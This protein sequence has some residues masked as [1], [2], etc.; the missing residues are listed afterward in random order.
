MRQVLV[1]VDSFSEEQFGRVCQAVKEWAEVER[2]PQSSSP[3]EYRQK[4]RLKDIIVGWPR[5]EWVVGTN[6]RLLL[7]GS[8]GWDAYQNKGLE[9]SGILLCSGRGV[10]TIGVAEHC[11]AMMFALTRRL[12]AHFQDKNDR[13]FRRLPPY[14]EV[15][16]STACIVGL[17]EIG[18]E[19][20]RRCACLGMKVL[21]IVK[22]VDRAYT[23]V[24]EYPFHF[25]PEKGHRAF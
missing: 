5:P 11:I 7:I 2:I 16:G 8:S 25:Q 19:L 4:I 18:T 9:E 20:A 3:D 22:D 24:D 17:G 13:I 23:G 14:Q 10:Y 15:T 1:A 12:Q 6:V 21:G